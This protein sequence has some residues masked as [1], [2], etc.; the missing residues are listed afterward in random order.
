MRVGGETLGP[1]RQDHVDC[2]EERALCSTHA[3]KPSGVEH[4]GLA[5][6][7]CASHGITRAALCTGTVG[8]EEKS[9]H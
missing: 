9:K 7:D 2:G 6:S 5:Q 4:P 3:G 8:P 1:A